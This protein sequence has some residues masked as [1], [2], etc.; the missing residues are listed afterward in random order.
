M[1]FIIGEPT[2]QFISTPTSSEDEIHRRGTSDYE[3]GQ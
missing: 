2:S 1:L 3:Q